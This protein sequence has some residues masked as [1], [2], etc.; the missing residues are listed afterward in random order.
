MNFLAIKQITDYLTSHQIDAAF[1]TSPHNIYYITD[2]FSDPMERLSAL[3]IRKDGHCTFICPQMEVISIKRH[4]PEAHIVSYLDTENV[5]HKLQSHFEHIDTLAIEEN[6]LTTGRYLTIRSHFNLLKCVA[7]DSTLQQLRIRKSSYEIAKIE[8]AAHYADQAIAIAKEHLKL[9]ISEIELKAII[10]FEIKK[11]G[12]EGMSFD[13]MVLFG[14]HAAD[15][16]G[17][18]GT[19]Q[20]QKNEYVLIDLG[21]IYQGYCS[22]ITRV[23]SFGDIDDDHQKIYNIVLKA[24]LAAIDACRPGQSLSHIDK[25]ARQIIEQAG[26]GQYFTHRLGHGL[27]MTCHEFPDVSETSHTILEE[28]MVITIEPGIYLPEQIGIRI[29]DDI[30][31]TAT[32]AKVLTKSPK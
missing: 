9:G 27:G 20:L 7:I 23:L 17:H 32:G 29:E 4:H 19:R 1:I 5:Y 2:Y 25:I 11:L 3:L 26:Y 14:D 28:G 31:I 8:Q 21:C 13:T 18:S 6:H 24:N 30:V 10:E 15:P 16:H 22:D 12:V